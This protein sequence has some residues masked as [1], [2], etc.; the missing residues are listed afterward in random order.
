MDGMQRLLDFL[1]MLRKR[2]IQFSLSQQQ[3]DAIEVSFALVGLRVEV[4][5]FV[6]HV[7]FSYFSGH[8]DVISDESKLKKL[9]DEYAD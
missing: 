9:I 6:D 7:E 1:D 5:F 8:E 2:R 3:D 4:E